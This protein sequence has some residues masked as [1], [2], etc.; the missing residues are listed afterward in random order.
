MAG[1]SAFELPSP[2]AMDA[3]AVFTAAT[4]ASCSPTHGFPV[5]GDDGGP[6]G[7]DG[8]VGVPPGLPGGGRGVFDSG[9]DR[10]VCERRRPDE[11]VSRVRD[12]VSEF[13]HVVRVF[14]V[15]VPISRVEFGQG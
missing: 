13:A 3:S 5:D 12:F 7:D 10:P 6:A 2:A 11:F 1:V 9:V 8:A 15:C 4:C 14:V